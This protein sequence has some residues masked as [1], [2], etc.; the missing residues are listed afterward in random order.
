MPRDLDRSIGIARLHRVFVG[1]R[2]G[3]LGDEVELGDL[4]P[5][6]VTKEKFDCSPAVNN[7]TGAA[8]AGTDTAVHAMIFPRTGFEYQCIGTQTILCPQIVAT[9]LDISLDATDNEGIQLTQGITARSRTAFTVG[10]DVF[11]AKCK[12]YITDVSDT[13]DCA[14][15]FRKAEAY[16]AAIDDYDEMACLNVISGNI[17]IETILNAAATTSTDTTDDWADGE[18]HTLEVYVDINGAVTYKIDGDAPTVTAA[19]SFDDAEVVIPFF[20][21]IHAAASTAGVI[22]TDWEVGKVNS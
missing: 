22:L 19:F 16:Q 4:L 8:A 17:T 21:M 9:G 1:K 7:I 2:N 3:E 13:D 11:Y 6:I 15:G 12:F 20:Y 14:F 18:E 10:T 5:D